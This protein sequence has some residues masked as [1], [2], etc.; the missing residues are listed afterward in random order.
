MFCGRLVSQRPIRIKNIFQLP[1]FADAA[2]RATPGFR[3]LAGGKGLLPKHEMA[4]L[5]RHPRG[6]IQFLRQNF[7]GT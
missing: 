4:G 5:R 2:L 1:Q 7:P 6:Q 3:C